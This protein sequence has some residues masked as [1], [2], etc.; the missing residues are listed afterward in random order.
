MT[1]ADPPVTRK[2]PRRGLR[3]LDRAVVIAMIVVPTSFVVFLVWVPAILSMVLSFGAW[4]GIGELDQIT[5]VGT[6]N[7]TDIV[8]I[9]PAFWPAIRHNLIW[10]AFL[11]LGPTLLG[12]LLAVIL[13]RNMRGSRFY[14][15]AFY[16]PVVLSLALVGFIWQLFYSRDQGLINQVFN[17]EVD[18]YGDSSVNLWAVLVATAWRH[19]GYIMLIYLAGL[20]GVDGSLREA[21]AMDGANERTTFF[22]VI[23]PVMRPINMIV[24]VIVVIESL[25][26]FDLVWV[27][28]RGTNGLELIGALVAQNVVGEA[29]RYGFG[30]ALA[31]IMM[32]ISTVF[33][34]IY[35]RNVFK[36]ERP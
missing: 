30:S 21:A 10:L 6:K 7:Y 11:F 9:Y 36:E 34:A 33:I 1:S 22:R 8:D 17:S 12:I 31:V 27:V 16:M 29:S 19:T 13:D 2:R 28:N 32:L 14:Q 24:L 15:T 5:W 26:A 20:K 35:L 18:W 3:P 23:F 25:R 4:N